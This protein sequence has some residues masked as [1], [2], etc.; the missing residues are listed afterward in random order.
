MCTLTVL[1]WQWSMQLGVPEVREVKGKS[2]L[3]GPCKRRV[4]NAGGFLVQEHRCLPGTES[5]MAGRI[6]TLNVV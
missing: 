2:V 6:R 1:H 4:R 3:N 5:R